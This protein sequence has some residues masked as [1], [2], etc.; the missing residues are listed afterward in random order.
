VARVDNVETVPVCDW[1]AH[2]RH[3]PAFAPTGTNVNFVEVGEEGTVHL[4]TYEKGVEDETLSCGTGVLAAAVVV[5][6]RRGGASSSPVTVQTHGGI[7]RV[8]VE[9]TERG[10][11]RYLE[12]P[13]ISVFQGTVQVP[14]ALKAVGENP[15]TTGA[16]TDCP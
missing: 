1:G 6:D 11:Q 14:S 5:E 15:S 10:P 9:T 13:A 4:R 2:L 12:G 3:D 8:G 7:L 16:P